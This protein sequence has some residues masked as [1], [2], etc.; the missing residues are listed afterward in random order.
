[1]TNCANA[2]LTSAGRWSRP[3]GRRPSRSSMASMDT[4][5]SVSRSELP[6]CPRAR[7]SA[8]SGARWA[9][10]GPLRVRRRATTWHVARRNARGSDDQPGESK[11]VE[12][13][14]WLATYSA[15][16]RRSAR[17]RG[18]KIEPAAECWIGTRANGVP[19]ALNPRRQ[20]QLGVQRLRK[21]ALLVCIACNVAGAARAPLPPARLQS[22]P[23]PWPLSISA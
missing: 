7:G 8:R 20:I 13:D 22:S 17:D 11:I 4:A 12:R 19:W 10:P 23:W 3:G 2:A 21:I 18:Q 5:S 6:P 15:S 1:M 9:K 16:A 14:H